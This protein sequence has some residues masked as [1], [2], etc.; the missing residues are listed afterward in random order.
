MDIIHQIA[1]ELKLSTRQVEQTVKLLDEGN[2]IP[3]IA[4][5][6]K[7]ATGELD[8]VVIRTLADRLQ[9]L[10][11]L[12]TRKSEII[13]LIAEQDKL[14]DE[15]KQQIQKAATLQALE[16]IY[17]PFRPKRRTR[18]SIAKEK[19]L[20]PLAD[21]IFQQSGTPLQQLAE[22]FLNQ[23]VD[24]ID[25]ALQGAS[26][27]LAE[28]FADDP[29][30][31]QVARHFTWNY[32]IIT[33]EAANKE[34]T[35]QDLEFKMY[36]DYQEPVRKI[37][38]HRVLAINRGERLKALKVKLSV[39]PQPIFNSL[40]KKLITSERDPS[41][42]WLH[43]VIEDSYQRLLAPSIEREIR[44]QL[45]ETAE[46]HSIAVFAKNLRQLLMQA[47]V[48][49]R[50]LLGI[51]PAYRTGCKVAA[52][53]SYG[54]LLAT[55]TI[56]PHEPHNQWEQSLKVLADLVTEHN[57]D[58]ITIGNGTA[59]RETEKLVAELIKSLDTK[60]EYLV[61]NEAGASVYSASELARQEFPELDVSMRGAVSIA[62]RV[63]DPL[64]ELVKIDPKS[65]GVG[66]YQHDVNQKSLEKAL[67]EVVESCVNY[68]GVELNSASPALL[69]HVSGLTAPVAE[70]IAA[71]RSEIGGFTSRSQLKE[72]KGLGAK[73][74]EQCAGFLRIAQGTDPLDN[75]AVHP[76]SY[77]LARQI[78]KLIGYETK[79]L[80]TSLP[81]IRA[82]LKDLDPKAIAASLNA[83]EPTVRDILDALAQP[84][85]DPRDELPPPFFR[86]DVLEI[87]DL[88]PGMILKGTVQNVVDFGAFID[89]GVQKA[90][91]VHISEISEEY[92]HHP[93]DVLQVGDIVTVQ[94]LAVDEIQGRISLTMKMK[95]P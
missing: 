6:R 76:E 63:I 48:R 89:I 17:R 38:P 20:E 14:T 36:F 5:Y 53:N 3:F 65:I 51:D 42:Q 52:L 55:A 46:E 74:F 22:A 2:T 43:A 80:N 75:T 69:R 82:K 44:N 29:S 81:E 31:R 28:R 10:R 77:P 93:T 21:L 49:G 34:P 23:E 30:L 91:L 41:S 88:R 37:P 68:V 18:A 33:C 59:S 90:G 56:Y 62:R 1:Q 79:D 95:H 9:Y 67:G 57:I 27:I 32:G 70:R 54:D 4:R 47:P 19:G 40:A 60:L 12:E 58:L 78:L 45:T 25:A 35:E 72:I 50:N 24:S 39:D 15:I 64:A 73:T 13:N 11:N 86:G 61:V 16:D 66:L 26:D 83:G 85:R 8:E 87:S 71:Y 92:I 7:E 84:G 94:V